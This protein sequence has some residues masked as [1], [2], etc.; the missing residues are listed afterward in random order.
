MSE[1]FNTEESTVGTSQVDV[2]ECEGI[3]PVASVSGPQITAAVCLVFTSPHE[4][5]WVLVVC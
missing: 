1:Q 5:G 4:V 2:G 3:V